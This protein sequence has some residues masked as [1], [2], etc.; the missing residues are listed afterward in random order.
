MGASIIV[1]CAPGVPSLPH[2]GNRKDR[3]SDSR[4]SSAGKRPTRASGACM[5]KRQFDHHHHHH[6]HHHCIAVSISLG[7]NNDNIAPD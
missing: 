7:Q 5:Q 4:R 2:Q 1:Y 3:A 6:H